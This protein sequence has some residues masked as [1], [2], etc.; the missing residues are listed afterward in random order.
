MSI[1]DWKMV[2]VYRSSYIMRYPVHMTGQSTLHFT[3]R[4]VPSN[5]N[6]CCLRNISA[7]QQLL[8]EDYSF[9]YIHH[10]LKTGTYSVQL[11]ELRQYGVNKIVLVST[12]GQYVYWWTDSVLGSVQTACH[13]TPWQ[14]CSFKCHLDFSGKHSAMLQLLCEDM[15]TYTSVCSQ[16]LIYITE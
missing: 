1:R 3:S 16:I 5:A 11:S 10:C 14:T 7:S 8:H 12:L 9:I 2:M 15:S 6:S 13:F 4:P